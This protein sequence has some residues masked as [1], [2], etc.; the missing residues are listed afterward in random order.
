MN[1]KAPNKKNLLAVQIIFVLQFFSI[2][3]SLFSE[4]FSFIWH[5]FIYILKCHAKTLYFALFNNFGAKNSV[6]VR[7]I[8][9]FLTE[10]FL[11]YFFWHKSVFLLKVLIIKFKNLILSALSCT[12][13]L[14]SRHGLKMADSLKNGSRLNVADTICNSKNC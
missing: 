8:Y 14:I 13:S 7:D 1:K 4:F 5:I 11:K 6:L 9:L 3:S 2:T 12:S 10:F